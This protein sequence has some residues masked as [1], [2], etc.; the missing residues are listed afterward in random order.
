MS[1]NKNRWRFR[2]P[3]GSSASAEEEEN[4]GLL[5]TFQAPESLKSPLPEDEA[6]KQTI[7][8][9]TEAFAEAEQV[10]IVEENETVETVEEIEE[11]EEIEVP[12]APEKAEEFLVADEAAVAE[13]GEI[14]KTAKEY[15]NQHH[16]QNIEKKIRDLHERALNGFANAEAE[17]VTEAP[18]IEIDTVGVPHAE[19]PVDIVDS[20]ELTELSAEA[21]QE[22]EVT[23]TSE[24]ESSASST[25]VG[26]TKSYDMS[27]LISVLKGSDPRKKVYLDGDEDNED[28]DEEEPLGMPE[29]ELYDDTNEYPHHFE[30]TDRLQ[31]SSLFAS[32]RKSAVLASASVV[33]TLIT[34]LACLWVELGHGAGLPFAS[35]MQPGR[36]GRVYA[37]V[38]LQ[39][40]ALCVLW[41]LD[42]LVRGFSK[43]APKRSA[44]EAVA[45]LTTLVCALHTIYTAAF[46]YESTAYRTYCFIGCFSL[47]ILS[48]N[49]FVK[50]YTRFKAFALVLAKKPK[51]AAKSL[52]HLAE[53]F[54][55]FSKYLSEDS[56]VLAVTK[57]DS[58]SDFVKR[59]YTVPKATASVGAYQYVLLALAALA[60]LAAAFVFKR[61]V[62][63]AVC[64]G[65]SVFLLAS[66]IG[67]LVATAFPYFTA[68]VKASAMRSTILGEAACDAYDDTAVLSFDD[69]V[70]FPPKAVKVSNIKTYNEHRIDKIIVY[71]THI[72]QKVGGPLSYV[73][74]SS[75][76]QRPEELDVM[77]LETSADGMHLKVGEDDVLVGTGKYLRLFGIDAP[78]DAADETEMRSLTSIL[79]LVCG[80]KPAAKFYI[81]YALNRKFEPILRGLYDAGIC[82]GVR[83]FDP[84]VDDQLIEGNLKN[85]NYPI[86]AVR[87]DSKEIERIESSVSDS[88]LSVSSVHNYLKTF[89]LV[90]RL[91]SLYKTN[92]ILTT[93]GSLIGLV[94]AVFAL[95]N[96]STISLGMMLMY[97]LFWLLPPVLL[98]LL[99]K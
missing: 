20:G 27:Q 15:Y 31:A 4:A 52:D 91:S 61:P 19:P 72:F 29:P 80:G 53:E 67:M 37:M 78:V 60:A 12:E 76:D 86:H 73:F 49:T 38:S 11:I 75:L 48:L 21:E 5:E 74:A 43:L 33:L 23:Q 64:G 93:I 45:T 14:E 85:T 34:F 89:L 44:P 82:C 7:S 84:G 6:P 98:S 63:E 41:N 87:K 35:M 77:V 55:A 16:S 54:T 96:G 18:T 46:A 28:E 95:V 94:L 70:V 58:V 8:E 59:T 26:E 56:E 79:Y 42:G 62:Y 30:Y 10:E 66:P 17:T 97:Q 83:T 90:D 2:I 1:E 92:T 36:F 88:V 13:G 71:M 69:T 9:E 65:V 68:S 57:T 51:F 3:F 99:G 40:L 32:F 81:R 24:K 39:T 50:A 22:D 25:N 47:L